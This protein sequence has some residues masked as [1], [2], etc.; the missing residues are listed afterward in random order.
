MNTVQIGKLTF[1]G[2]ENWAELTTR[3]FMQYLNWRVRLGGT[4]AG[5][6][7]LLRLWYGISLSVLRKLTDEQRTD[8]LALL[9][10]IDTRPERWMLP[11]IRRGF[12]SY[13]GPGDGLENLTY[14]EFMYAEAS[15][16]RYVD[17]EQP[18]DLADLTAAL[19]RPRARFWQKTGFGGRTLFDNRRLDE[20]AAR[21]KRLPETI[22]QGVL[23][24]YVGCLERF[25]QEF[26]DLYAGS[27]GN[28]SDGTWLDV[29]LSLARST[30][31]LGSFHELERTNLYLV[32]TTLNALMK[33]AAE[34]KKR[35]EQWTK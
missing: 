20:Q 14:G 5:R 30:G 1:S 13:V 24:N 10:F 6:W 28:A 22:L 16:L 29:G 2:P 31:A 25:P 17:R 9:D 21:L 32:L 33:E 8:L 19:Y 34:A 3:Q 35:A 23:M 7:A 4:P 15:R 12:E 26:S 27:S 18:G 11:R